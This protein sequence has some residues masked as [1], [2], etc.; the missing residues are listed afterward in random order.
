MYF[1]RLGRARNKR[2][3]V[4]IKRKKNKKIKKNRTKRRRYDANEFFLKES[5]VERE[6]G[7]KG[8]RSI[9]YATSDKWIK[10]SVHSRGWMQKRNVSSNASWS[11][12]AKRSRGNAIGIRRTVDANGLWI[13]V[14]LEPALGHLVRRPLSRVAKPGRGRRLRFRGK[15]VSAGRWTRT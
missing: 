5:V 14:S 3:R 15:N 2:P 1:L 11:R 4:K 9:S 8:V 10:N 6:R 7:K 12:E 13:S